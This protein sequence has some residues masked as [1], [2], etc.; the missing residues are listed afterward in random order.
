MPTD[1]SANTSDQNRRENFR[2]DDLLATSVQKIDNGVL[3]VSRVIPVALSDSGSLGAGLKPFPHE[4]DPSFALMLLEAN[5]KLDLLFKFYKLSRY[6]E[7][8]NL[9]PSLAQLL[10]QVNSKLDSLLDFH[11]IARPQETTRVGEVSLSASGIKLTSHE[12][13]AAGDL[14]EV[15]MLLSTDQPC[16]VVVGGSVA[17]VHPLPE[18]GN[19]VAIQFTATN[20]AIQEAIATYALRK[21]KEQLMNQRWLEP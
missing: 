3:P 1:N 20:G 16:W 8:K 9:K 13:L 15:H 6:N 14:V 10:L 19:Q 11:L 4:I 7:E 18:G 12:T 2:I 17:R 21:Q 5:T